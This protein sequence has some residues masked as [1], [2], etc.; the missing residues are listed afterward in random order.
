LE[1]L[2]ARV[3]TSNAHRLTTVVRIPE[4]FRVSA[5]ARRRYPAQ[6]SPP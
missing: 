3:V 4:Q 2:S 5:K 1:R 6:N